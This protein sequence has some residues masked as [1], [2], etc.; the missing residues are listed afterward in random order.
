MDIALFL[1]GSGNIRGKGVN[2]DK[3]LFEKAPVNL[4]AKIIFGGKTYDGYIENAAREGTEYLMTFCIKA[5]EEFKPEKKAEI[6][7]KIP[8]SETIKLTCEIMWFF[9]SPHDI[10]TEILGMEIKNPPLKYREFIESLSEASELVKKEP[11]MDNAV[12]D[13]VSSYEDRKK[14]RVLFAEESIISQEVGCRILEG[15]DCDVEVVS[16]AEEVLEGLKRDHFDIILMNMQMPG[17]DGIEA[18]HKIRNSKDN[19]FNNQIPIIAI[20]AHDIEGEKERC[21]AAG[22]NSCV[23]KPFD[24]EELFEEI[25]KL[26][27]KNL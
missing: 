16:N 12:H 17:M 5:S 10:R 7:F 8:A 14:I 11:A 2:V 9:V 15:R 13:Y 20:T 27:L 22:M 25:E 18:A 19:V 26:A 23:T 1:S 24:L 6:Y 4:Y 3:R 21:L